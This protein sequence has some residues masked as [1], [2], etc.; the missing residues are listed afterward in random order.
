MKQGGALSPLPFIFAL[1]YAIRKIQETKL[2]LDKNVTHQMLTYTNDVNLIGDDI[3][4]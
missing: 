1:E 2:V 3:T 4:K